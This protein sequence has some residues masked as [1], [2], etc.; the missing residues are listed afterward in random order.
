[1]EFRLYE[2]DSL[3]NSKLSTWVLCAPAAAA[4]LFKIK[5][6]PSRLFFNPH[7]PLCHK[8]FFKLLCVFQD[9]EDTQQSL[10]FKDYQKLCVLLSFIR[11]KKYKK[12][13][14]IPVT[15]YRP[16]Y[17]EVKSQVFRLLAPCSVE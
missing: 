4:V 17:Y 14:S 11:L 8:D 6:V 16:F 9:N 7:L 10:T 1:M 13:P 15:L 12:L 5:K 2:F 3:S